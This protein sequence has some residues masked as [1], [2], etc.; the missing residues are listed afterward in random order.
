[1]L[2]GET[3]EPA[4][5]VA[6]AE[7]YDA[8]AGVAHEMVMMALAAKAVADLAGMVHQ[9]VH[10]PGLAEQR[11]RPVDGGQPDC[12][13]TRDE[14]PVDLLRGRVVRLRGQGIEHRK[15][16]A[17]GTDAV[18]GEEFLRRRGHT[19]RV[20]QM[21]MKTIIVLL[22]L[23]LG[24]TACGTKASST[25]RKRVVAAFYP[26]AYAAEQLG[27][28]TVEV[29]NLT[30]PG[31]EPHDLEATPGD[32]QA[33]H[34]ADVVL[35]LGHGFQPQLEDAAGRGKKVVWLLDTPGLR[36]FDNGDP[37]VWLD[38]A[39]YAL[40][41][42]R[43]GR[44]LDRPQAAAQLE[45]RLHALDREYRRGL[46]HCARHEI[47]TSHEAFAYLGQHYGL[48]QVAITG[49]T[50]EAEPAPKDLQRV[51]ELVRRTHATTIFFETLV[52]P[53]IAETV[54]R[55]THAKTAVLDPIEGI[56]AA[57]ANQGANYFT[58]MRANLRALRGALGC[59]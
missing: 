11:E 35:L 53:R 57:E 52:S 30:P 47:V 56:T 12:I 24:A 33:I 16:L 51:V 19:R 18:P 2:G 9:R 58:V 48:R 5:E 40:L 45:A 42:R 34:S 15:P 28:P 54:A 13:A 31:V 23:L 17:R 49:L 55:E 43:I 29:A 27:G 22:A 1:M 37:H 59:R 10:D 38:P 20:Q 36:R 32:V 46:A 6:V 21:R 3:G 7:L 14:P 41:V 39:R 50:P 25:G 4:V 8:V 44:A 26:L